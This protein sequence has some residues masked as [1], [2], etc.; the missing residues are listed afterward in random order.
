MFGRKTLLKSVVLLIILVSSTFSV[1][2]QNLLGQTRP[3]S[4]AVPFLSIAPDARSAAMG[5]VGVALAPTA[6]S[7][8]WNAATLAFTEN[9][10][11]F[12]LSY[13]PWLRKLVNDMFL[14]YLS[15][16]YKLD[17]KQT[18]G[19][20]LRYFSLGDISF[21]D[22]LGFPI[23]DFTPREFSFSG[24][25]SRKLSERFGIA[26]SGRFIY[27]NLSAGI[28]LPNLQEAKAGITGAVDI[29]AYYTNS[30]IQ[31]GENA[32]TLSFGLNISN[33][34][35]KISYSNDNEQ[36]FIPT[37]FRI[38]SAFTM[39]LDPL[40]RNALTFALDFNKLMVPTPPELDSV[41]NIV[42]G[43][44]PRDR[45]VLS[46]VFGSFTDAPDGFSEELQE[47][48]TSVGLEYSYRDQYG[49][50]VFAARAGYFNEH[51]NKGDRK[52][53]TLGAGINYR[54]FGLDVAYLIPQ[55]QSNNN[56]LAETLRFTL[57]LDFE[58]QNQ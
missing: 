20:A 19:F 56:P 35:A 17:D 38:G 18:V 43:T 29:G 27:S 33:I 53:F 48:T 14:A 3:L 2:A 28:I 30:D 37:N 49:N 58:D 22:V 25:Y 16:Y 36:D 52:Y 11:G 32:A 1:Q 5:D 46:G 4:T 10:Y 55:S 24:S 50:D 34:G 42:S 12:S 44:N 39:D 47:I 51:E 57:S 15:G 7:N 41:G 21:T 54:N 40:G 26:V 6:N 13:S 8:Y 9:Q 23:K 31:I 45:S